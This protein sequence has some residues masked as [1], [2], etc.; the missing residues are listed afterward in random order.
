ME[1]QNPKTL[2]ERQLESGSGIRG[3]GSTK[4]SV[5]RP[6]SV[7]L[8]GSSRAGRM[9]VESLRSRSRSRVMSRWQGRY[10]TTFSN[11]ISLILCLSKLLLSLCIVP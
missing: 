8:D 2:N 3:D 10:I 6:G 9:S 4:G 7:R 1:E 5:S 11:A